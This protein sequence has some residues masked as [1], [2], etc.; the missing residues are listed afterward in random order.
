MRR[1]GFPFAVIVSVLASCWP[2]SAQSLVQNP[3]WAVAGQEQY[4]INRQFTMNKW[5]VRLFCRPFSGS[6]SYFLYPNVN[7][8]FAVF[9][10]PCWN[11]V[12][13]DDKDYPQI[14]EHGSP[15]GG[16]NEYRIPKKVKVVSPSDASYLSE[17]FN[18]FILDTGNNRIQF[19]RYFWVS[20]T[21]GLVNVLYYPDVYF[22]S[23]VDLDVDVRAD[24][25]YDT[26]DRLW[27]INSNNTITGLDMYIGYPTFYGSTGSGIG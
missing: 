6:I 4:V 18:V 25:G 7:R 8:R 1:V 5:G 22:P 23:P 16:V 19:L 12:L 14:R 15:G 24:Y 21:P 3:V 27:V 11:R 20:P 17:Y 9:V 26:D 2:V 10:D 13:Y